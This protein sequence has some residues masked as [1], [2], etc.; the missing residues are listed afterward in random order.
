MSLKFSDDETEVWAQRV[1][2]IKS[3]NN[4]IVYCYTEDHKIFSK[5]ILNFWE[6]L[7]CDL[8]S[9]T[10]VNAYIIKCIINILIKNWFI[11]TNLSSIDALSL[12]IS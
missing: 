3:S 4:L 8:A 10:A 6:I 11:V 5:K 1:R 2:E 12:K 9:V 7:S